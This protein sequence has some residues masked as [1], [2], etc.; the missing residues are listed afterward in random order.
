[1]RCRAWATQIR[2]SGGGLWW[3]HPRRPSDCSSAR[4]SDHGYLDLAAGDQVRADF[5]SGAAKEVDWED[6]EEIMLRLR[7]VEGPNE[8][9]EED[10][11]LGRHGSSWVA[12]SGAGRG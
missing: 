1:M 9:R 11:P 5:Y 4:A 3:K 12:A 6:L 10:A 8:E 7:K 2:I